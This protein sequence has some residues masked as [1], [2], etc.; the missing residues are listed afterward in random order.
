M[1]PKGS[2]FAV[3]AVMLEETTS[4]WM[5]PQNWPNYSH[6][7]SKLDADVMTSNLSLWAMKR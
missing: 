6:D 7:F 1:L 5:V 2:E 3:L 4:Q